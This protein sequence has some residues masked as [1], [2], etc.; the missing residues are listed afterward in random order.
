MS[1]FEQTEDPR[2]LEDIEA[3]EVSAVDRGAVGRTFAIVKRAE[4][5]MAREKVDLSKDEE[6]DEEDLTYIG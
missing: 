2:R 4:N 1:E 5:T 6:E 3:N